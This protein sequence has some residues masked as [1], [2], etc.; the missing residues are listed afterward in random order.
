[1]DDAYLTMERA[2]LARKRYPQFFDGGTDEKVK[3]LF[4][5][6]YCYPL[7][8]RDKEGRKIILMQT[9]RLN[10]DIYSVYDAIRLFIYVATVLLEEEE[11]QIAGIIFIFNHA[12][13]TL[14]HIMSPVDVRDFMDFVK[15]CSSAR[16]KNS[17][18]AN[19]PSFA[20][21][22]VS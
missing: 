2:Y 18:V 3:Q 4:N 19:L 16:I 17:Y 5:T 11:T 9:R 20:N 12:G 8:G 13:I 10:T 22:M 15:N 21:F 7:S 6:G 14:K 1:M